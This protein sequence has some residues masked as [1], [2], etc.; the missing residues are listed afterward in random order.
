[1]SSRTAALR[2]RTNL[3]IEAESSRPWAAK[4]VGPVHWTVSILSSA[5]AERD[6]SEPPVGST[7]TA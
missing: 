3:I 2:P 6:K 1:M 4:P 5:S 7:S